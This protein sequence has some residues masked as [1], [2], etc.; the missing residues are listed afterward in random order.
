MNKEK[1][2]TLVEL[3]ITVVVL[4]ILISMAIPSFRELMDKNAVTT[5]AN[6]LLS[7][8]LIARSEA[9]K[10]ETPVVIQPVGG[11]GT[12]YRVFNDLNNNNKYN[13]NK[14]APLIL[15]QRLSSSSPTITANGAVANYIRFS[16]RGRASLNPGSDFFT[17]TKGSTTRHVCFSATG[18]PRIQE[19]SCS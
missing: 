10:R 5:A 7:S 2:F 14:E 12:R 17:I 19:A 6:D 18:R 9:I 8:V 1:G 3:L 15:D 16:P 4:S 13:K 11:W